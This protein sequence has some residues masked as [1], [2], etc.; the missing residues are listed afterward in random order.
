MCAINCHKCTNGTDHIRLNK[1]NTI[2]ITAHNGEK[3]V[4][5]G[6]VTT[7]ESQ[8]TKLT[9]FFTTLGLTYTVEALCVTVE[10]GSVESVNITSAGPVIRIASLRIAYVEA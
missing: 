1:T 5:I 4:S 10:F 8:L 9:E 3:I 7:T 6:F 2:S